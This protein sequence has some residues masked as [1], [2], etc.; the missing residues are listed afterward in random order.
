M[1]RGRG[2]Y[3]G[4]RRLPEIDFDEIA[5]R[6]RSAKERVAEEKLHSQS[7]LS[8]TTGSPT[9]LVTLNEH[10]GEVTPFPN[11]SKLAQPDPSLSE[12]ASGGAPSMKPFVD[13][14]ALVQAEINLA[15]LGLADNSTR[16]P[17]PPVG[18]TQPSPVPVMA[19]GVDRNP[20]SC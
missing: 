10:S 19:A 13:Y 11:Q 20:D 6:I 1:S 18:R 9:S 4:R 8:V 17:A 7:L 2:S 15:T 14:V 5:A 3:R 16:L 12:A